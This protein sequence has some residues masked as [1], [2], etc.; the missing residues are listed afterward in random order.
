V[1]PR[2]VLIASTVAVYGLASGSD[3]DENTPRMADDPYGRSKIEA[4]DFLRAWG[5]ERGVGVGIARLPLVAGKGAPGN[6]G[7]MVRALRNGRYFGVGDGSARRSMV[8]ADDVAEGLCLIAQHG[9]GLFHLTDRRHPSF[10]ELELALCGAL[11]RR[12][13]RRLPL[14]FAQAAGLV[15]SCVSGLGLP[16]PVTHAAIAKMTS[17]LTFDDSCAVG[18]LGWAPSAVVDAADQLI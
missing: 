3:I 17:S 8:L 1:K 18:A 4:E 15:G 7:A 16:A 2:V 6:L 9:G 10:R 11:G 14:G 5:E 12:P 13:P